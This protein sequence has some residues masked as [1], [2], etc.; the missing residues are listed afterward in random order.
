MKLHLVSVAQKVP[1][2]V[3]S[4]YADYAKRLPAQLKPTLHELAP[5]KKAG[6]ADIEAMRL[7]EATRIQKKLPNGAVCVAMHERGKDWRT[8]DL[9]QHLA[10]WM[11]AGPDVALIIGGADGLDREFL[12]RCDYQWSLG[13][14]TL[15]HALVRVIV[16]EQLYRAWS[17]INN[18]PYHRA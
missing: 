3:A 4:G 8:E 16:I 1:A 11:Q 7:D 2:W 13:R 17:I 12:A 14:I 18:H 5:A 10:Q 15:P 6:S 9:A